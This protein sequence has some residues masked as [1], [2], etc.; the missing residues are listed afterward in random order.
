MAVLA[1]SIKT[2]SLYSSMTAVLATAVPQSFKD[3]IKSAPSS[4]HDQ[5]KT[6]KPDWYMSMPADIR[7]F[8]D[9]NRAA[10]K[11]IFTKD[12]GP[13]PTSTAAVGGGA[14]ASS[15][16]AVAPSGTLAIAAT[17]AA[18]QSGKGGK[19]SEADS[20]RVAGAAVCALLGALGVAVMM[21]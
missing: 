2:H 14:K 6:A 12:I 8:M 3:A 19:S 18:S 1:S 16:A 20:L 4:I 17:Q 10:A 9:H 7:S 13:L 21:L 11:S 5:Y 15:T